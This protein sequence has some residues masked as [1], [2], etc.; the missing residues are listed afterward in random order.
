METFLSICVGIGLSAACGFRVFVP[1]LVMSIASLSGHMHLAHGFEW[2]GT[3]PALVSFAVATALEIAGYYVPWLDHLLDTIATPAAIVAGTIATASAVGD[4]SPFLRWTLG[5]IAGGG[6]AG[7]I[8]GGTV[9]ARAASGATTG[10][11]ANPVVSSVE[12]AGA[13]ITSI[14]AIVAPVVAVLLFLT[15]VVL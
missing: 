8:Q 14:L 5:V 11:M 6:A 9:L 4:M 13:T 2:I 1:L 3:Y 10:G 15:V 7:L 12:L